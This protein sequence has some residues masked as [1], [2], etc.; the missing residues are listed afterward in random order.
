MI[1]YLCTKQYLNQSI[2]ITALSSRAR[3]NYDPNI[4]RV[5]S[6]T[7]EIKLFYPPVPEAGRIPFE[8]IPIQRDWKRYGKSTL[9]VHIF[10][11]NPRPGS[12]TPSDMSDD[13]EEILPEVINILYSKEF[14]TVEPHLSGSYLSGLFTYSDLFLWTNP[15][16]S[17]ESGSQPLASMNNIKFH[18][19]WFCNT[20]YNSIDCHVGC[21]TPALG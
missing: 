20:V 2:P 18:E 14:N 15:H 17:N 11:G 5:N 10:Q 21:L 16:S 6:G 3:R 12:L 9:R 19:Y 4:M 8:E 13:G 1:V 7:H